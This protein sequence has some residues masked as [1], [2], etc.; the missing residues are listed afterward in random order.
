MLKEIGTV[1][2]IP[3]CLERAK[4]KNDT[5]RLMGFGHRVY[6]NYDPRAKVM[7]EMCHKVL[8]ITHQ[9][10]EILKVDNIN[11][12]YSWQRNWRRQL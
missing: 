7:Q 10:S 11:I 1:E 12:M 3:K 5:F 2:N 4:S 6:K 9:K 8:S